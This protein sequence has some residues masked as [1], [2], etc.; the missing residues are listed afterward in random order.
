MSYDEKKGVF[1][2]LSKKHE[3]ITKAWKDPTFKKKLLSDPKS[4]LKEFGIEIPANT[5]VKVIEDSA[6]T[7][8][9][10]IPAAPKNVSQ[11]SESELIKVAGGEVIGLAEGELGKIAGGD[12]RGVHQILEHELGKIHGGDV[13]GDDV[14]EEVL[15]KVAGGDN[16]LEELKV[17]EDRK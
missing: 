7:Y 10:V 3:V 2:A 13:R 4:A 15:G 14:A 9:F 11:L 12:L 5:N 17:D 16:A 6:N 8:T 1:M